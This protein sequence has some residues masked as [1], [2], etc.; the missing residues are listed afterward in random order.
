MVDL[1]GPGRDT[2]PCNVASLAPGQKGQFWK[3]SQVKHAVAASASEETESFSLCSDCGDSLS[4]HTQPDGH[5]VV[6]IWV[7]KDLPAS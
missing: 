2:I 3:E 6:A 7:V 5:P 1:P 4:F